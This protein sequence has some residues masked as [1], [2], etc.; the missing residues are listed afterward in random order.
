M[1]TAARWAALWESLSLHPPADAGFDD[2]MAR[3][4][5]PHR[6][7]HT[8]RHLRECLE[9]L[10]QVSSLAR[11]PAVLELA[12]WYHDAVYRPRRTDNE[13]RSADL[14]A[15]HLA[16]AGAR[17]ELIDRVAELILHTTHA[18][19]PP[20]GDAALLVDIDLAI[21]G[22]EPDRFAE[23]EREIRREYRWVPAPLFRRRRAGLLRELLARPRLFVTPLLHD[24]L[25]ARARANLAAALAGLEATP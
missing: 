22:A 5:E 23:Y 11:D 16:A 8:D 4:R 13:R 19:P 12:L 9:R 1:T 2:M 15:A 7:Y 20:P 18:A 10:D 21:L 25:E 17:R 24:R 6:S 3:Y 14:A